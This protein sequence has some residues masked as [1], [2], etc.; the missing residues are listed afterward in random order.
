MATVGWFEEGSDNVFAD[1][2]LPDPDERL[3]QADLAMCIVD[4]VRASGMTQDDVALLM[5]V[6][7][8]RV[9]RLL[10]GQLSGFSTDQ[11]RRFLVLLG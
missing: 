9:S 4:R 11:L 3:V 2:G 10:V 1:L 5:G 7:P 8:R 6:E